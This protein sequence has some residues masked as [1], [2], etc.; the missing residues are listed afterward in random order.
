MKTIRYLKPVITT[1][2]LL[3][4]VAAT[5]VL[6]DIYSYRTSK[7]IANET[8]PSL[9]H[10]TMAN[11]Y[12]GQGFLHLILALNATDNTE[13]RQ[14]REKIFYYSEQGSKE[15]YAYKEGLTSI[16]S[17]RIFDQVMAERETNTKV[18]DEIMAYA[19]ADDRGSAMKTL[20]EKLLPM[21]DQYLNNAQKMMDNASKEGLAQAESIRYISLWS[22]VL[23]VISSLMIFIFGF[24]LGYTR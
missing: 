16:N 14:Q 3:F 23:T 12:R 2:L 11:Q 13:Y 15:L 19:D 22:M 24:F 7:E 21:Y 10:L 6:G 18:R 1:F 20:N 8:L 9:A 5:G 4:L 17:L